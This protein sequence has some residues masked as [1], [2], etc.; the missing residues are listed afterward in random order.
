MYKLGFILAIVGL[1]GLI[2]LWP[3]AIFVIFIFLGY[4]LIKEED[5][6][7]EEDN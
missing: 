6:D 5:D 7:E 4:A 2:V 3:P 1:I